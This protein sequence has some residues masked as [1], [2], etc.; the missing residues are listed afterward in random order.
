M[1]SGPVL[2]GSCLCGALR[3]EVG[4]ALSGLLHCHCARCR[5]HH[6]AP[7]ASFTRAAPQQLRWLAGA[8]QLI[9][10]P[11]SAARV[12]RACQ[13]CGSVAPQPFA[14]QLL[15]PV[16][17][18][19]GDPG[20]SGGE[21]VFVGSRA[22]W[23]VI[24]D[25]LPQHEAAVPG[26]K[27]EEERLTLPGLPTVEGATH[28]SCL[29]GAVT[30]A[31]SGM[32]ARWL[33]CHCSRCRRARSAAHGSNTFYPLAQFSW[34]TGRELVRSYRPPEAERFTTSF[35]TCCGGAAPTERENVPFVLVPAALFDS[36][37]GARPQ[38]HI[39]VASMA[40]WYA[41]KDSL[42]QFAALPPS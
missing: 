16:G 32:P 7:F 1:S 18:L 23:H 22:G 6:G 9:D 14:E 41:I 8:E 4:G 5:K 19:H 26:W 28:G 24:A 37:P 42:P 11:S 12:R 20:I 17:N 39:H 36:D 33:Q 15:L 30:F 27:A 10:Y 40:S 2:A 29:C 31:V 38:A 21:H 25:S 3:Y 13:V 35:C 34:R